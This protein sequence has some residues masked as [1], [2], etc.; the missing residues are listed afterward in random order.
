MLLFPVV[1]LSAQTINFGSDAPGTVPRGWSVAM[2]HQGGAPKWEI[3]ADKTAPS[4]QLKVVG[5]TSNDPTDGRFPLLIYDHSNLRDGEVSVAFKPIAGKVDSAAG[6]VW[7]YKDPNTYYVA[8]ANALEDNVV[9]Y[10]LEKGERIPLPPVGEPSNT[11]GVPHRVPSGAWSTLRITFKGSFFTVYLNGA[12]L[13]D[14]DDKT[15]TEA[16]KVGLWTKADSVT[17]FDNFEFK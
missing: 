4:K 12:K 13:F 11:Y 10:K 5:Q 16:G 3:V 17:Y 9:L 7:R 15:F 1:A 14:V 8:R 6:L 2:T